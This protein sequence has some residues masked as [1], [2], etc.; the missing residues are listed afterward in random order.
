MTVFQGDK[1]LLLIGLQF[2]MP[3]KIS[4]SCFAKHYDTFCSRPPASSNFAPQD[5]RTRLWPSDS[6]PKA[7]RSYVWP[8]NLT[9]KH[10]W[11]NFWPSDFIL[12]HIRSKVRP[13]ELPPKNLRRQ[14]WASDFT[15][16]H[17]W[18]RFQ[19]SEFAPKDIRREFWWSGSS[20]DVLLS[21]FVWPDRAN[22]SN[23]PCGGEPCVKGEKSRS[24]PILF[25]EHSCFYDT[26]KPI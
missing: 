15:P 19:P 4:P 16:K 12:K 3:F 20:P 22:H 23:S 17:F 8:S 10:F 26:T 14:F 7:F 11:S 18:R 9:P 5:I 13:S 24:T 6:S 21:I 1:I 2:S 25:T